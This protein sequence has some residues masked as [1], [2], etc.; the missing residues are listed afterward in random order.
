MP[1]SPDRRVSLFMPSSLVRRV[2]R[3]AKA[4]DVSRS[5]WVRRACTEALESQDS[6]SRVLQNPAVAAAMAKMLGDPETVRGLAGSLAFE[7]SDEQLRLF[8]TAA[9][10]LLHD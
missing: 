10:E 1:K 7:L 8:S 3:A 9:S 4:A 5:A 2:D 6:L